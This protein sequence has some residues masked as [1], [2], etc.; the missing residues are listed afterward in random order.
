MI[1]VSMTDFL[2]HCLTAGP[3]RVLAARRLK[4]G[5]PVADF[6]KPVREA[7]V[8]VHDNGNE[9][10]ILDDFLSLRTDP[11]ERR[12]FPKVLRGYQRFLRSGRMTW[13]EPPM[14]DWPLGPVIVRASPEVG[15]LIDGR[16][17]AIKLYFGSEEISPQRAQLTTQILCSALAPTW[18]GT[19]FAVLDVRRAK[20]FTP[21]P[22]DDHVTLFRAEAIGFAHLWGS[23]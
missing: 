14:R 3:G 2:D 20:L 21:R 6:Y 22:K 5:A 15:L 1:H 18:P 11:R 19:V 4:S 9:P 13:F 7:I 10:A 12:I 8:E 16:P 23:L 17:H